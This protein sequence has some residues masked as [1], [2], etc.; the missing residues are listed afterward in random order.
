MSEVSGAV[1][2]HRGCLVQHDFEERVGGE[3]ELATSM[4]VRLRNAQGVDSELE[5]VEAFIEAVRDRHLRGKHQPGDVLTMAE[6]MYSLQNKIVSMEV[7]VT[8]RYP[9]T[10]QTVATIS[11]ASYLRR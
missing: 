7:Q 3:I 1:K 11:L 6:V 4:S 9:Y 2:K 8:G 10:T 5:A